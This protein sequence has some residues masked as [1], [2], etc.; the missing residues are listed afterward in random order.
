MEVRRDAQVGPVKKLLSKI[1]LP[2]LLPKGSNARLISLAL[3]HQSCCQ[4]LAARKILSRACSTTPSTSSNIMLQTFCWRVQK[5]VMARESPITYPGMSPETSPGGSGDLSRNRSNLLWAWIS[6][7]DV[8]GNRSGARSGQC[9][10]MRL[11]YISMCRTQH[12]RSTPGDSF[13]A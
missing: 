13:W 11:K 8:S 3:V 5:T 1:C 6:S 9:R 7:E 10:R 4:A 2:R 12:S